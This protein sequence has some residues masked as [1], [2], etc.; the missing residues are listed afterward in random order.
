MGEEELKAKVTEVLSKTYSGRLMNPNA[1]EN[2]R[3]YV[4]KSTLLTRAVLGRDEL[5][6]ASK[7]GLTPYS[8]ER[9]LG[10]ADEIIADMQG[11]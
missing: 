10:A 11:Q 9:L 1:I 7:T 4:S 8:S 3:H 5:E 6:L 2:L